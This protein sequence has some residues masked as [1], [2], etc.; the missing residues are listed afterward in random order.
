MSYLGTDDQV[1]DSRHH[2]LSHLRQNKLLRIQ[3]SRA[4]LLGLMQS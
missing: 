4:L 2:R 1:G 3:S